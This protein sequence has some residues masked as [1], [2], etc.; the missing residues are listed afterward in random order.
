MT[1]PAAYRLHA[2]SDLRGQYIAQY[3]GTPD[4]RSG[5]DWPPDEWVNAQLAAGRYKFRVRTITK[6]QLEVTDFAGYPSAARE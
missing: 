2:L 1:N 6:G 3:G 5:A 4:M